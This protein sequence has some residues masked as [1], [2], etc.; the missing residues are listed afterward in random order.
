MKLPSRREMKLSLPG[1]RRGEQGPP[2]FVIAAHDAAL[3]ADASIRALQEAQGADWYTDPRNAADR[4]ALTLCRLRRAKGG[5]AGWP[6]H[7]DEAVREALL[8]AGP[9]AIAWIASRAISYMDE[10][11]CPEAAELYFG[12][13]LEAEAG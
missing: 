8:E 13:E 12:R 2:G 7:G 10:T 9:E 5:Q 3:H 1:Q 6:T 4:A 11:G